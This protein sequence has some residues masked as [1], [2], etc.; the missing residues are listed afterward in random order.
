ME[1]TS[2]RRF[3]QFDWPDNAERVILRHMIMSRFFRAFTYLFRQKNWLA[4]LALTMGM[5]AIP[6]VGFFLIRGWEFEI[7]ARVYHGSG[8]LLPGW[9][10]WS[11][12][13]IRGVI[14][15]LTGFVYN[16]P[17]YL[18]IVATLAAWFWPLIRTLEGQI[19]L[20]TSLYALY[21]SGL[22]I[23]IGLILIT[24]LV[25]F[26]ANSLYWAG[27]LRYVATRRYSLFFDLI[28]NFRIMVTTFADDLII[29]IYMVG[30]SLIAGLITAVVGLLLAATGVCVILEPILLPAITLTILS[31]ANGYWMGE[32]A[33]N[34]FTDG[35]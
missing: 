14:I 7:S 5:A 8:R 31:T 18:L 16:L 34:T 10:N 4:E 15:R 3:G 20:D 12:R 32:L 33:V 25:A 28:E 29:A 1:C 30:A 13:L 26:V 35:A 2:K 22:G 11:N 9:G 6:V 21:A 23:R 19:P 24:A 17:V 27:Y